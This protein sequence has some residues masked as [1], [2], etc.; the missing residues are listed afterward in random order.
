MHKRTFPDRMTYAAC[1]GCLIL[2]KEHPGGISTIFELK[3][4]KLN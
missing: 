4:N 3:V 1:S 2:C